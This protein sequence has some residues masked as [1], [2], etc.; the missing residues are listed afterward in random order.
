VWLK[1]L[2]PGKETLGPAQKILFIKLSFQTA[3]RR[4][5]DLPSVQGE[6][7]QVTLK[8][9]SELIIRRGENSAKYFEQPQAE[10]QRVLDFVGIDVSDSV[11]QQAKL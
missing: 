10:L 5:V 2:D 3:A 6:F 4:G 1:P 9:R 11:I 8:Q 7:C